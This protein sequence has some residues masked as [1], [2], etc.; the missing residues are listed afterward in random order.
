[1]LS[2]TRKAEYR[3]AVAGT[4]VAI[5]PMRIRSALSRVGIGERKIAVDETG[6][7]TT[8]S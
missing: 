5:P 2:S 4:A 1:M 6:E 7:K 3:K 8:I